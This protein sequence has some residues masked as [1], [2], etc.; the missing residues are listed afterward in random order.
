MNAPV[1][2]RLPWVLVGLLFLC[3]LGAVLAWQLLQ[4]PPQ[5]PPVGGPKA[6]TS[7]ASGPTAAPSAAAPA[8]T[9]SGVRRECVFSPGQRLGFDV[10]TQAESTLDLGALLSG[11]L[12]TSSM[13]I[14]ADPAKRVS[15]EASWHLDVQAVENRPDGSTVLAAR[16]EKGPATAAGMTLRPN[17]GGDT[18]PVFLVRL[19]RNCAVLEFA[20]KDGVDLQGARSQQALVIGLQW[21]YPTTD[22]PGRYE[23][24]ERDSAG[25]LRARYALTERDA[26]T[27]V[28]RRI[29]RYER[30]FSTTTTGGREA[31]L[32]ASGTG[33]W[34]R[35][36]AGP[37][38][39]ALESNQSAELRI[40][41]HSIGRASTRTVAK[42]GSPGTA[43]LSVDP[44]ARDWIWGDLFDL[45][46]P[47]SDETPADVL[48][49]MKGLTFDDALAEY[50]RLV[51]DP[52]KE[53]LDYVNFLRDWVRAHP[54]GVAAILQAI[55]DDR[56]PQEFGESAVFFALAKADTPEARSGLLA[57]MKDAGYGSLNQTRA[58]LALSDG[59]TLPDGYL[60]DLMRMSR[61]SGAG[62]DAEKTDVVSMTP[63]LGAVAR[64]Q[65]QLNPQAAE[66][67]KT[68][69]LSRL[70]SETEPWRV[71]SVLTGVGNIGGD[72]PL[73][74]VRPFLGHADPAVRI[75]A[76]SALREVSPA[77]AAAL[78][79]PT[80][81][82]ETDPRV[83]AQFVHT[84][85]AQAFH[86]QTSPPPEV[87][88]AAIA[89][90]A[91]ESDPNVVIEL[92]KLLGAA[93]EQGDAGS[94]AA[95][96]AR[97]Q[98]EMA[99]PRRN[100]ELLQLLGRFTSP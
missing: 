63:V 50:I 11:N 58:A 8:P 37:W 73:D 82:A 4:A 41:K 84:Y 90:L 52:N 20:R 31:S 69:L 89:A 60:E 77:K 48:F 1:T 3:A 22:E 38:F 68:E 54:E 94:Q 39:E 40:D 61:G 14:Q 17:E 79:E 33:L 55:R 9:G 47:K 76:A 83:R 49:G 28:L 75:A 72:A 25:T 5:E 80:L 45:R 91:G 46:F 98:A 15:I 32:Q 44:K 96:A 57:M 88:Q 30:L 19:G 97:L 26:E 100:F 74:A 66:A 59:K 27:I 18:T 7:G 36:G 81:T 16:I 35:P 53:F 71:E 62:D 34:V 13:Q 92:V 23:V 78:F 99:Q 43:E 85:W 42:A 70:G 64:T 10:T 87:L 67:A 56:F 95:L 24:A 2:H 12:A 6:A 93:A 29:L 51:Q 86:A 65:A 21:Q